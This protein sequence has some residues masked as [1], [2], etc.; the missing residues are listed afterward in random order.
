MVYYKLINKNLLEFK[1]A[2]EFINNES[3]ENTLLIQNDFKLLLAD[4]NTKDYL[5]YQSY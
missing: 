5:K 4:D 1:N 3:K 2:S